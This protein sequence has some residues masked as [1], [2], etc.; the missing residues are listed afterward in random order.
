MID[1]QVCP[2]TLKEGF[3][4]FSPYARKHFLGGRIVSHILPYES[5]SSGDGF[6]E[7]KGHL[8]LSGAQEKYAAIIDGGVFR[9]TDEKEKGT[10]ILKPILTGFENREYSP[11]NENL[12]MQIAA[13]VYGIQTAEN[14]VCFTRNGEPVYVTKRFDVRNDGS[15]LQQEDLASLAGI[16]KQTHGDNFKYDTLDYVDLAGIIRKYVPAWPVELVRYFDIVLFNFVFANGDAHVKNFSVLETTR[17]DFRLAPAYDLINTSLHIPNDRIFAL[18]KG[19]Y[20]DWNSELGITGSDFLEFGRRIGL[21]ETI[22]K[23]ELERF[24]ADYE[25]TDRLI[26]H[27]FLS[28]SLKEEYRRVYQ[29]RIHSYLRQR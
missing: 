2:S 8:S 20:P 10:Y 4:T 14:A 27:S 21:N 3:K 16:S 15:K 19:L 18:R 23:K 17:G 6:T 11:A 1:I 12:T 13:Q 7:N 28:V 5:L 25:E 26:D 9:L 24:C 29:T 22:A